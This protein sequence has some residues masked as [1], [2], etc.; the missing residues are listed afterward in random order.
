MQ[1]IIFLRLQ[2]ARKEMRKKR[3]WNGM[4]TNKREN[5]QAIMWLDLLKEIELMKEH[6]SSY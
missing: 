3:E 1:L 2:L 4:E 5:K 6:A